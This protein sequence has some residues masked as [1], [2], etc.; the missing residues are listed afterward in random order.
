MNSVSS[1]VHVYYVLFEQSL[2]DTGEGQPGSCFVLVYKSIWLEARGGSK[3]EVG[4][5]IPG[6]GESTLKG[7]W[8]NFKEFNP[9]EEQETLG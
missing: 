2:L 4:V 7:N 5:G 8:R 1:R 9:R 6:W 3:Q